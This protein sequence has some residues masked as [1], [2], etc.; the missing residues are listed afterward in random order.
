MG[1]QMNERQTADSCAV[2]GSKGA[3]KV[4][5]DNRNTSGKRYG[6]ISAA[7]AQKSGGRE[8]KFQE[9]HL[10]LAPDKS[11]VKAPSGSGAK[12][13]GAFGKDGSMPTSPQNSR[14]RGDELRS[15]RRKEHEREEE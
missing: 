2:P 8:R 1:Q 15:A 9:D 7:E 10:G 14:Y 11:E 13:S 3:E 5:I 12:T 4:G 6:D